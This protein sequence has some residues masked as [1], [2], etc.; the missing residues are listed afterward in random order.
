M[1]QYFSEDGGMT[2][3]KYEGPVYT[4]MMGMYGYLV[5]GQATAH[6]IYMSFDSLSCD[7]VTESV[8]IKMQ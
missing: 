1:E 3:A 2:W 5:I 6:F 8:Q 7:D 4:K